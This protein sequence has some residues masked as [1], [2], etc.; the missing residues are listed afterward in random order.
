ML[1][2]LKRIATSKTVANREFQRQHCKNLQ[3]H[4]QPSTFEKNSTLKKNALANY[5]AGV[6][7]SCTY[8]TKS[9]DWLRIHFRI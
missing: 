8:I 6:V 1:N 9:L 3:R 7:G 2:D 4:G 5:N